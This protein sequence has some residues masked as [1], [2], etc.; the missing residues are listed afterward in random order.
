MPGRRKTK[1]IKMEVGTKI[2]GF[3]FDGE[4]FVCDKC[5]HKCAGIIPIAVH[6]NDCIDNGASLKSIMSARE[7]KG[8][9]LTVDDLDKIFKKQKEV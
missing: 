7:E 8:T 4:W 2:M 6:W 3:T 9:E 1:G 5:G